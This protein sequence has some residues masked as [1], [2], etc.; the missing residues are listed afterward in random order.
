MQSQVHPH[1]QHA[2][3][4]TPFLPSA[5][6]AQAVN[7]Y[8]GLHTDV[9]CTS[10]GQAATAA[11]FCRQPSAQLGPRL[12]ESSTLGSRQL[13]DERATVMAAPPRYLPEVT[14]SQ[15]QLQQHRYGL[16]RGCPDRAAIE[17]QL[18]KM[19]LLF[20]PVINLARPSGPNGLR[21]LAETTWDTVA[22]NVIR[23]EPAQMFG[24][25]ANSY[26]ELQSLHKYVDSH[27]ANALAPVVAA[28]AAAND[29]YADA[30]VGVVLFVPPARSN[31]VNAFPTTDKLAAEQSSVTPIHLA[32]LII[33]GAVHYY[34]QCDGELMSA[35][36]PLLA[37]LQV[38]WFHERAC[39]THC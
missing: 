11:V 17:R 10:A 15:R 12:Q 13:S 29:D 19:K 27:F 37:C 23:W 22:A 28:A 24:L 6:T 38:C 1:S 9:R 25:C 8:M 30:D 21:R 36:F 32:L 5:P 35:P 20:T 31:S 14:F 33:E 18:D 26:P 2:P 7:T 4:M 39:P 34:R 3:G 16:P